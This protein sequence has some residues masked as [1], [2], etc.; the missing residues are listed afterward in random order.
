MALYA[1]TAIG[2]A[3]F[4]SLAAGALAKSFG[5]QTT[6]TM[7]GILSLLTALFLGTRLLKVNWRDA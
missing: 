1:M 4:G 6:V 7:G 5:A 2:L 3:P